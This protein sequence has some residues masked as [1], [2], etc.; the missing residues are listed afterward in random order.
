MSTSIPTMTW[1]AVDWGSSC[2]RVWAMDAQGKVLETKQSPQGA[3]T[4]QSHEYETTL[5]NLIEPWLVNHQ[6]IPVLI[7]GMAG[8]R[9]GWQ[10]AKYLNV[11]WSWAKQAQSTFIV[12][13]DPR[14]QVYILSGLKQLNPPDVM[15][16][17]ETQVIG[18]LTQQPDFDGVVILPGTHSKWVRLQEGVI[19]A[20]H[21]CMTGEL[22]QLLSEQSML[23]HSVTTQTW[24]AEA[25]DAAFLSALAQPAQLSYQ[26]FSLRAEHLLLDTKAETLR[27]KLSAYLL[28]LEMAAMQEQGF[29]QVD[30]PYALI[31]NSTLVQLYAHSLSLLGVKATI[32]EGE[33][34]VQTGLYRAYQE[35]GLCGN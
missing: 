15:R 17:E 3:N 6:A 29:I 19:Q 23:R 18:L 16:G 13:Q 2:L 30:L 28:A 4:L 25:F 12:T 24:A 7:A 21:T 34:L 1:I 9:Q 11:P 33:T 22:F 27:T 35:L 31:G 26:L 5:L 32:F 14:I 8:S 20:F 10:E